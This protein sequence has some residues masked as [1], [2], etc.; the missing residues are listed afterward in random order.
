M[1]VLE[2]LAVAAHGWLV[3]GHFLAAL[4]HR[5]TAKK[6]DAWAIAHAVVSAISLGSIFVHLLRVIRLSEESNESV[7]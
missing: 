3:P 4:W 5:Y 7:P 6:W 1:R 2:I